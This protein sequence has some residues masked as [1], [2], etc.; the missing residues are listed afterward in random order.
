MSPG[1]AKAIGTTGGSRRGQR[2]AGGDGE[3]VDRLQRARRPAPRAPAPRRAPAGRRGRS[4]RPCR[5]RCRAAPPGPRARTPPPRGRGRPGGRRAAGRARAS[6]GLASGRRAGGPIG[7]G[8][9][10][11]RW[12][13]TI[14]SGLYHSSHYDRSRP[15]GSYWEATGGPE[16]EGVGPLARRPRGRRRDRRRRLHR[17]VGRLPPGARARDPGRRARG[18]ADRL[19]RLGPQWRLLRPG[20]Q[21]ARLRRHGAALGRAGGGA[22]LRGPEGRRG[23]GARA[24]PTRR[25]STSRSPA[26]ASTTSPT[27]PAAGTSWRTP[28]PRRSGCSASAGRSGARRRWRS[29]CCARPEAQGCLVVPHYFGLHP[30]RYVRGLAR[31]AV[32]VARASTPTRR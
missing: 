22:V 2:V 21:Q 24:S 20:R 25:R 23:A 14:E 9:A 6:A 31:A 15:V 8:R 7:S 3:H 5:R 17:P 26:R 11:A 29:G 19:G 10:P 28:P 1:Q 18:R 12:T 30:L 27:A 13:M 32:A 16:P 4:S